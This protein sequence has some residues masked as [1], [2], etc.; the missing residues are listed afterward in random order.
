MLKNARN[1]CHATPIDRYRE[2]TIAQ[3]IEMITLTSAITE[4]A[5]SH[6]GNQLPSHSEIGAAHSGYGSRPLLASKPRIRKM[7][8]P[9]ERM[10]D[11]TK[12]ACGKFEPANRDFR[13]GRRGE[14]TCRTT[15]RYP[16]PSTVVSAI[17]S[18]NSPYQAWSPIKGNSNPGSNVCPTACTKVSTR[19]PK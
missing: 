3:T 16:M 13:P 9:I 17:N 4:I 18:T 7:Q 15:I 6:A 14:F 12:Y 19:A 1:R 11:S 10:T 2:M 8:I 5:H